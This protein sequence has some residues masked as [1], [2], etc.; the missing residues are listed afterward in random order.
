MSSSKGGSFWLAA[1]REDFLRGLG[2]RGGLGG[3][4]WLSRGWPVLAS[5]RPR[6]AAGSSSSPLWLSSSSFG[7]CLVCCCC[8]CCCCFALA[9]LSLCANI[10]WA[11]SRLRFLWFRCFAS[12][13]ISRQTSCSR[14][15]GRCRAPL[16]ENIGT[17]TKTPHDRGALNNDSDQNHDDDDD[18]ACSMIPR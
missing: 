12:I 16:Y 5:P 8:C 18:S 4:E 10:R 13:S 14:T 2:G 3:R 11:R 6:P 15:R 1:A 17:S 7:R 9:K